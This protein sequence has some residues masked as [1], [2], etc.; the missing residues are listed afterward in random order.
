MFGILCILLKICFTDSQEK[1]CAF[2]KITVIVLC[3]IVS[4]FAVLLGQYEP[5]FVLPAPPDLPSS[6]A[7]AFAAVLGADSPLS[8]SGFCCSDKIPEKNNLKVEKFTLA[9]RFHSCLHRVLSDCEIQQHGTGHA[10][11]QG[12]LVHRA[13]KYKEEPKKGNQ[14]GEGPVDKAYSS[15]ISP[16]HLMSPNRPH[17]LPIMLT[18]D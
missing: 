2:L 9:P 13:R 1:A 8:Y 3:V 14:R 5:S 4:L 7:P 15:R 12:C 10:V 6:T 16:C 17:Y 18:H 11:E